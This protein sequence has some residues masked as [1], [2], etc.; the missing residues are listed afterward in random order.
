MVAIG[1]SFVFNRSFTTFATLNFPFGPV[2]QWIPACRQAGNTSWNEVMFI[3]YAMKSEVDGRIYV[4]FTKDLDNR[5]REHNQGKTKSTKGYRP[6]A[7]MYREAI[8]ERTEARKRE[9]YLKSG[10]GKEFL[11]NLSLRHKMVP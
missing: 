5:V 6:W 7:L 11:K 2:V 1:L 8:G 4:G 10:T 9:K 3:L